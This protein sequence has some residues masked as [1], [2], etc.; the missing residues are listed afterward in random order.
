MS[1]D[2]GGAGK[3]RRLGRGLSALVQTSVPIDPTPRSPGGRTPR[4][5]GDGAAKGSGASEAEIKP[6]ASAIRA[7]DPPGAEFQWIPVG[8]ISSSPFQPR[9]TFDD[10]AIRTLGESI[11]RSGMMQP[12]VVR[13]ATEG[14]DHSSPRYE[15]VAGERRW[16]AAKNAGLERVPAI[17]RI[18]SDQE[19]AELALVENLQRRDLNAVERAFAFRRLTDQFGLSQEQIGERVGLDR[20]S[21]SNFMRLT[22]LEEEIRDLIV[23]E[24]LG[25]GHG[26]VLLGFDAGDGRVTLARRA[27]NEGWS[28]RRL[29]RESTPDKKTGSGAKRAPRNEVSPALADLEQQLSIHLGTRVKIQTDKSGARGAM[30]IEFY[31]LD[32]FDGLLSRF[33]YAPPGV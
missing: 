9:T 7:T 4:A 15:L 11:K 29:E 13:P 24:R 3:P 2:S 31:D 1:K 22:E 14:G 21:V 23:S 28:V 20:S 10:D 26:K 5:D 8:M 32:Q 33:G 12:L 27:A 30:S 17:V 19:A 16:R 25:S 6:I 18:L